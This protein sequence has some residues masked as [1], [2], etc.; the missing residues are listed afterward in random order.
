M[1][2]KLDETD[3]AI[4]EALQRDARNTSSEEIASRLGTSGSTIRKRIK[5]LEER[6]IIKGYT[7]QVDYDRSG[8]PLRMLLYCTAPIPERGRL[9][10]EVPDFIGFVRRLRL[11]LG[12]ECL[13][14]L[15]QHGLAAGGL[16]SVKELVTGDKNLLV[17]VVGESDSD[18]TPVAQ[19]LLDMGLQIADEVLVRSMRTTTFGGLRRR[20][21]DRM[22]GVQE[23][24]KPLSRDEPKITKRS[25]IGP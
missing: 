15:R 22:A 10:A 19:K 13:A 23:A 18:V 9:A 5:R 16:L 1:S 14:A 24:P 21:I 7:A 3:Q 6:G 17:T 2:D 25:Q 11:G 8:Y 20:L 4:L 12:G